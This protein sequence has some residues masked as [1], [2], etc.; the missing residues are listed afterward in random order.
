MQSDPSWLRMG[1]ARDLLV[2][3][4]IGRIGRIIGEWQPDAPRRGPMGIDGDTSNFSHW[5]LPCRL[6]M[7]VCFAFNPSFIA[8][9]T[10]PTPIARQSPRSSIPFS[11]CSVLSL[12]YLSFV[13]N[14]HRSLWSSAF[15]LSSSHVIPSPKFPAL[16]PTAYMV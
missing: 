16:E 1:C 14:L 13:L 5:I 8:R 2:D 15:L 3:S 10:P 9:F 7:T 12:I 4:C 6:L 11:F